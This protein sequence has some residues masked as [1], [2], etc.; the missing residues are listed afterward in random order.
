MNVLLKDVNSINETVSS[1][2]KNSTTKKQV[3]TTTSVVFSTDVKKESNPVTNSNAETYCICKKAF[4]SDDDDMMIE[5]D[6][7]KNWFH[8]KLVMY[9]FVLLFSISLGSTLCARLCLRCRTKKLIYLLNKFYLKRCVGTNQ[10]LAADIEMYVCPGCV[11]S[12]K[13]IICKIFYEYFK[14]CICLL[15]QSNFLLFQKIR[16]YII[17]I[18]TITAIRMLRKR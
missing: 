11:T 16:K 10:R 2:S 13:Q 17:T 1:S 12:E 3:S 8:G 6:V 9:F 15:F 18:E 5:C 4:D 14:P 7:C